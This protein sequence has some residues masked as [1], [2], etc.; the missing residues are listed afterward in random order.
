M[1]GSEVVVV[2]LGELG[3]VFAQGFLRLGHTV[4]PVLRA[5][6]RMQVAR[7]HP[8]PRLV[9]VTVAEAD[10]APALSALPEGWKH[11]AGLVQNEL[12]PGVWRAHG[13]D[14]PT[15]AVVWFEK[16][17]GRAAHELLPTVVGGPEA[18]LLAAALERVALGAR[19]AA[20]RAEL[21]RALVEKNVYIL[22][23]NIAGLE[24][25][26]TVSELW[27]EHR[28]LVQSV[29]NDVI[30][31]QQALTGEQLPRTDLIGALERAIFADPAHASTGRSAPARLARAIASADR[32]GL[33]AAELR[34]IASAG[35]AARR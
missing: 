19:V 33:A 2:G 8:E 17:P 6:D 34:R 11:R 1:S 9:L 35:Y 3:S 27:R 22:T 14:D 12:L 26:G 21:L 10:L 24:A 13:I 32:H 28:A 20:S 15:V 23:T 29:A 18:A 7:A 25:A 30:D 31:L 16:K 5:T 4:V